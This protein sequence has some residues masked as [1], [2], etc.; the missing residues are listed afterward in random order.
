MSIREEYREVR[1]KLTHAQLETQ[2]ALARIAATAR[3]VEMARTPN[4]PPDRAQR[5]AAI[6]RKHRGEV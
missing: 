6:T 4:G 2:R 1:R 5:R 3:R